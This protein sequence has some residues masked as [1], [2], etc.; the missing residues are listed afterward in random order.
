MMRSALLAGIVLALG[1]LDRSSQAGE[2][3]KVVNLEK[4]NT[5]A[6]EDDPFVTGTGLTLFYASN[7]AG[8]FDI[9]LSKRSSAAQPF[10]AGKPYIASPDEDERSP[11]LFVQGSNNHL[12]YATNRVPDEKFK[13]LKNFDIVRKT[14]ERAP[15]ALLG[16]SEKEDELH[17]WLTAGGKEFY[18]SR[19]LKEGWVMFVTQGDVPGPGLAKQVGFPPGFCR[20]TLDAKALTM[21]L[22]GPLDDGR[23]GI[24]RSKRMKVGASWSKPELLTSLNHPESKRG[25]MSPCLSGDR[26]YFASDRPGGKGGLDIW[27]ALVAQLK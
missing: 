27:Y 21:Y 4:V 1:L 6:D 23:L 18:F 24:Y 5:D 10:P 12:Y 7:K 2:E 11:F 15:L 17:P 22:H 26:L 19:K 3:I 8:T 14:G 25:A 9:Y 20:A 13:D 16:V